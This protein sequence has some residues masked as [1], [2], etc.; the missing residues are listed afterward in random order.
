MVKLYPIT[1]HI[2]PSYTHKMENV[3]V[4]IVSVTSLHLMYSHTDIRRKFHKIC[5]KTVRNICKK[6]CQFFEHGVA[7]SIYLSIYLLIYQ[8]IKG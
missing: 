1:P 4:T 8:Y 3:F 6:T 5:P 2:T 7:L